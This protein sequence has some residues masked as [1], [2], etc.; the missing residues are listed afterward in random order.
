MSARHQIATE[1]LRS[2]N[3]GDYK[4][5]GS[6]R[7]EPYRYGG[8]H[9]ILIHP[10]RLASAQLGNGFSHH[11]LAECVAIFRDGRV[12]ITHMSHNFKMEWEALYELSNG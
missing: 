8:G 4:L 2:I 5:L 3:E 9:A 12:V 1:I 6:L 10:K 7:C 11:R